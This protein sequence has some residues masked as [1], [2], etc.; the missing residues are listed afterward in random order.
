[1]IL[2][3]L[4]LACLLLPGTLSAQAGAAA[5]YAGIG[6]QID[7][8]TG[9]AVVVAVSP[10]GPA[11]MAG[12]RAGDQIVAIDGKP[13]TSWTQQA[14]VN[15]LRGPS[16]SAVT[17]T[18]ERAGTGSQTLTLTRAEI[19]TRPTSWI[20]ARRAVWYYLANAARDMRGFESRAP[21]QYLLVSPRAIAFIDSGV[22]KGPWAANGRTGPFSSLRIF[23][24][25]TMAPRADEIGRAHV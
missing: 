25:A 24:Y 13:T 19:R 18:F 9:I 12:V 21:M 22:V 10:D 5:S 11:G 1:M 3:A 17:V 7:A 6:T 23:R 8:T 15:A 2:R 16:A 20:S 4:A 14:V